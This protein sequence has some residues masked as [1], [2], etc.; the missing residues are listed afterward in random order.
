MYDAA[1]EDIYAFVDSIIAATSK[2]DKSIIGLKAK[3]CVFRI[4]RDIRF[5]KDK[6]P[7]KTNM[8]A[9]ISA[10]GK[11]TLSAGYY[12]HCEPGKSMAAGGLYM[13]MAPQLSRVRQEIDYNLDEWKKIV[14]SKSFKKYFEKGVDG[15]EILSRPPKGYDDKNPALSYLKMKSFIA[16]RSFSDEELQNKSAANEIAKSFAAIKPMLDFLNRSLE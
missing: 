10:G 1:K 3:D 5:S 16:S 9:Y 7:Y 13:P 14:E 12:F 11:K 4:N 2:F 8:G 15:I 6:S